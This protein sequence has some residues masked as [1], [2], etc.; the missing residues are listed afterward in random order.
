MTS[1]VA[2]IL[3]NAQHNPTTVPMSPSPIATLTTRPWQAPLEGSY[4][5]ENRSSRYSRTWSRRGARDRALQVV[6]RRCCDS[7]RY[8]QPPE[9]FQPIEGLRI[10]KEVR[11]RHENDFSMAFRREKQGGKVARDG[12]YFLDRFLGLPL[13]V[14]LLILK[15]LHFGDIDR[16][17]KTCRALRL[18]IDKPVIRMTFPDLSRVLANTCRDCLGTDCCGKLMILANEKSPEQPLANRCWRCMAKGKSLVAGKKYRTGS[19]KGKYCV[20]RWCGLFVS[21]PEVFGQ[22]AE[23]H[24]TCYRTRMISW[25]VYMGIGLLQWAVTLTALGMCWTHFKEHTLVLGSTV[26]SLR[27]AKQSWYRSD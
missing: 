4:E 13:E 24:D 2:G 26:V 22:E 23:Y 3:Q 16:L 18:A 20:C 10:P 5:P 12:S 1:Y 27:Q 14:R 17:R 7:T 11:F 15:E 8:M 21:R 25:Y 6:Q 9:R 19:G